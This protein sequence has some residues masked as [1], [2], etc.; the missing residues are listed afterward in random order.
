MFVGV[1]NMMWTRPI[2]EQTGGWLGFCLIQTIGI[3]GRLLARFRY[4]GFWHCLRLIGSFRRAAGIHC[5]VR[6]EDDAFIRISL[7]DPYWT[8][9]LA[10]NYVYEPEIEIVLLA[11]KSV[12]FCFLDC[13]ANIGYWSILVC[14]ERFGKKRTYAL[15]AGQET[16]GCLQQ[17]RRLNGD[18]FDSFNLAVTRES[19][20]IVVFQKGSIRGGSHAGARVSNMSA[21]DQED[22]ADVERV[23]TIS[24]D[25]I[26]R[27]FCKDMTKIFVVKFDIEGQEVEALHGASHLLQLDVLFMYEDHGSDDSCRTSRFFLEKTEFKVFF[28]DY[29]FAF[30]DIVALSDVQTI[31]RRRS[32]GYNFFACSVSIWNEVSNLVRNRALDVPRPR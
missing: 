6:L 24:L 29:D 31:K 13:G 26:I 2:I 7:S 4:R 3:L 27:N 16:Y 15:E 28:L 18:A 21:S 9:I 32:V 1:V 8:R 10:R 25:D 19:G 20:K 22:R 14:S 5:T 23:S 12:D 17:N 11:L 30:I